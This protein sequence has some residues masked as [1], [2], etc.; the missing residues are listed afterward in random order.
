MDLFWSLKQIKTDVRPCP[1]MM[2]C[3]KEGGVALL[4]YF[5]VESLTNCGFVLGL[6]TNQDQFR[7]LSTET[8]CN[9]GDEIAVLKCFQG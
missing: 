3:N 9:N 1:L 8:A 6:E 2:A 5:R 4:K 7:V